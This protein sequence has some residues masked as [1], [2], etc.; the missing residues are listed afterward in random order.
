MENIED[1]EGSVNGLLNDVRNDNV[2]SGVEGYISRVRAKR[3]E[4]EGELQDAKLEESNSDSLIAI[5]TAAQE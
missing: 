2:D 5:I 1:L 3:S 4:A